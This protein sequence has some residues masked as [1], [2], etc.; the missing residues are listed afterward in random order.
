MLLTQLDKIYNLDCLSGIKEIPDQSIDCV[1]TDPPYG[2]NFNSN[3]RKHSTL[4]STNGILNDGVDNTD[5][6][7]QIIYEL[8]RVL[9]PNSHVYWFTR[10]DRIPL[11]MPLLQKY[12]KVK[13]S[14]IWKKN[15]WSMGDLTGAYAGQYESILF[16]Q[17]GRRKL[18][19]VD[20]KSRHSDILEFNR[21]PGNALIHSHQKPL[22]L[23]EF[24]IKKSSNENE[25]ILD[26]FMG[27]GTTAIAAMNTNRRFIGF[28]LDEDYFNLSNKRID[29]FTDWTMIK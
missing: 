22:D 25:I 19:E 13:N 7:Q 20:G 6:L 15:N 1:L 23:I 24:L 26:P 2:I 3:H 14:L 21:V 8:D 10:W 9:K 16:C 28:E 18:N 5:F 27:S 4:K 11:Q 29:N 17:K 12:F